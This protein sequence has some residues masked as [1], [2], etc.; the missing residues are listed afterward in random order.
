LLVN[1][2]VVLGMLLL[3]GCATD[4]RDNAR[5]PQGSSDDEPPTIVDRSRANETPPIDAP[6][7]ED[8]LR[9]ACA[10][11]DGRA[12]F[13]LAQRLG[14]VSHKAILE[15]SAVAA[16]KACRLGVNEACTFEGYIDDR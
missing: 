4:A 12:C 14:R 6:P 5:R 2:V 10:V 15:E 3:V 1:L 11:D 9:N 13:A 16:A 7:T 8:E